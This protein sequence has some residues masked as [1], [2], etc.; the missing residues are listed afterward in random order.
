MSVDTIDSFPVLIVSKLV[1]LMAEQK[2]DAELLH[3]SLEEAPMEDAKWLALS[4][5]VAIGGAVA[6]MEARASKWSWVP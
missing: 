3:R 2:H 1:V 4:K 5:M 6:A